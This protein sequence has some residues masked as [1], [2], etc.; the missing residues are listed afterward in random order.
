MDEIEIQELIQNLQADGYTEEEIAEILI[1]IEDGHSVDAA[2][3][4]NME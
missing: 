3:Q 1:L 4:W 2:M